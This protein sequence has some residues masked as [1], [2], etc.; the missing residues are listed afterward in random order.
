M[1]LVCPRTAE[2]ASAITTLGLSDNA[3]KI[4]I[5][6]MT[7]SDILLGMHEQ[8]VAARASGEPLVMKLF[9]QQWAAASDKASSNMNNISWYAQRTGEFW[10][11]L[12][13]L[14]DQR[15]YDGRNGRVKS[16]IFQNV[17]L[18]LRGLSDEQHT[19]KLNRVRGCLDWK[20]AGALANRVKMMACIKIRIMNEIKAQTK[21]C[22]M[23]S[24]QIGQSIS[25][26]IPLPPRV[27]GGVNGL[28]YQ[29]MTD[30][31]SPDNFLSL[32]VNCSLI[33]ML[34]IAKA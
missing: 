15:K 11:A 5:R 2:V 23:R 33:D 14:L 20:S 7:F 19:D 4:V 27:G 29:R 12:R 10:E 18:P 25:S 21:R 31:M 30:G 34:P 13:D 32:A 6:E 16:I 8:I 9:N 1:V 22:L 26:D 28:N 3:A 24:W 17:F